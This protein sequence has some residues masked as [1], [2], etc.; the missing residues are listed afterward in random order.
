MQTQT[1]T[2]CQHFTTQILSSSSSNDINPRYQPLHRIRTCIQLQVKSLSKIQRTVYN[3]LSVLC[4]CTQ[5]AEF[6]VSRFGLVFLAKY[7]CRFKSH[8]QVLQ[9][10]EFT[11]A[12]R[13]SIVQDTVRKTLTSAVTLV[14]GATA[15]QEE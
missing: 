13:H 2:I 12:P 10:D 4:R 6:R 15:F 14:T 7:F 5:S 9:P 8:P 3:A 11:G 1:H